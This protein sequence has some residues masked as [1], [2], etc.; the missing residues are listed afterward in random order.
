MSSDQNPLKALG[1]LAEPAT[2]LIEKISGAIEG[3]YR[4]RQIRLIAKAESEAE[5]IK[6]RSR[7]EVVALEQ[8][9]LNRMAAEQMKHQLN[10][11]SVTAKAVPLLEDGATPKKMEDDWITNFFDKCRIVSDSDMQELW[12]RVLAGKANCTGRFTRKTINILADLEKPDADAFTA[13]CNFGWILQDKFTPLVYDLRAEIY[14]SNG[15]DLDAAI[16]LENLGLVRLE[17][18]GMNRHG[19][20]QRCTVFYQS[21]PFTLTFGQKNWLNIGVLC[22]TKAGE[23]LASICRAMPIEGFFEYVSARW[24]DDSLVPRRDTQPT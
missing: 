3:L 13:L 9:A 5:K 4:P 2:K 7:I 17:R 21:R 1:N 14:N 18:L 12:A 22:L 11:E 16:Q 10:I 15:V 8:R 19:F 24:A 6:A 20:M 23:Q